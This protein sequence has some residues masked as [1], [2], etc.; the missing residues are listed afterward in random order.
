[1]GCTPTRFVNGFRTMPNPVPFR[2]EKHVELPVTADS[3]VSRL[4]S[5]VQRNREKLSS[6]H[7]DGLHVVFTY[8]GPEMDI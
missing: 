5:S 8:T 2:F 3:L 1:M 6:H 7:T 4:L